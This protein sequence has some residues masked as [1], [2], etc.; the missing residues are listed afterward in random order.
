MT[1]APPNNVRNTCAIDAPIMN[2]ASST[3][4]TV[5]SIALIAWA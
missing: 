5:A 2:T 4:A 3:N 1:H